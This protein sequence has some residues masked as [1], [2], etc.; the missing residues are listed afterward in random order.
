MVYTEQMISALSSDT[1][2]LSWSAPEEMCM[3]TGI[4]PHLEYIRRA[5]CV[6]TWGWIVSFLLLFLFMQ[7]R[8]RFMKPE[9]QSPYRDKLQ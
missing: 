1:Q 5:I 4:A 8:L 3:Y 9:D 7:A 6:F 2:V